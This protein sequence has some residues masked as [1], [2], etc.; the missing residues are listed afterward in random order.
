MWL[1]C[2]ERIMSMEMAK[3]RAFVLTPTSAVPTHLAI[4]NRFTCLIKA[5]DISIE[6]SSKIPEK[7]HLH[8]FNFLFIDLDECQ[9]E[10]GLPAN[11]AAL[12]SS[13]TTI[14]FNATDGLTCEKTALLSF[15]KGVFY[16]SERPD[17]ILKGLGCIIR[18]EYWFKRATMSNAIAYLLRNKQNQPAT[19][20][21]TKN[22]ITFPT[23]T[24]REKTIAYLVA[25]GAQNKEIADQLHISP[26]TVKTHL[27]SIFRKTRS[28]N[29]IE[30]ISRT[31]NYI[32]A[33]DKC[34]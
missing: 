19:T 25:R 10:N 29:R 14:L 31:Q 21:D 27:Y 12:A 5:C 15:V 26:N 1:Q 8:A 34:Y 24:K 9:E 7:S 18:N 2:G 30:L 13:N 17:I 16:R 6:L 3:L 22:D 33:M 4:H 28:R 23:L 32:P 11:I 20:D